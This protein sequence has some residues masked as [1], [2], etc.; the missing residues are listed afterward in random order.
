VKNPIKILLIAA[1][2]MMLIAL[3]TA[4]D[5][6]KGIVENIKAA[7]LY[8]FTLPGKLAKLFTGSGG[9]GTGTGSG[10][11]AASDQVLRDAVIAGKVRVAPGPD[12]T[13]QYTPVDSS[14]PAGFETQP[15]S[16]ASTLFSP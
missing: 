14:T 7:L 13:L 3:V 4:Y 5:S 16:L 11:D 15:G 9:T 12:G 6:A 2:V 1:G 8:P 10:L